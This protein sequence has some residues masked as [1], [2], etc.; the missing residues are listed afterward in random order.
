MSGKGKRYELDQKNTIMENTSPSVVAL[1]PD[2]SGNSK[3]GVADVVIVW[4][5]YSDGRARAAFVEMKKRE[6]EAGKRT[7]VMS[8]SKK[9]QSGLEEL[10]ELIDGTPPWADAYV[11]VKFPHREA[12][13]IPAKHLHAALD[14]DRTVEIHG[15]RLTPSD[16]ISMVMPTLDDWESSTSG[17]DDYRKLLYEIGVNDTYITPFE[18]NVSIDEV[19]A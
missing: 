5:D 10:Q 14:E 1:R 16:N 9:D 4:P 17:L 11:M 19:S 18:I 8:G 7:I 13:V 12:I 6:G 3:Y 15:A 2:F